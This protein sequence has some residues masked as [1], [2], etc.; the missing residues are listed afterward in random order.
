MWENTSEGSPISPVSRRRK[1]WRNGWMRPAP[2]RSEI[3]RPAMTLAGD[4]HERPASRDGAVMDLATGK[5]TSGVATRSRNAD[6][7]PYRPP[8][9]PLKALQSRRALYGR[10]LPGPFNVLRETDRR[11]PDQRPDLSQ[12][13]AQAQ[14]LPPVSSAAK[15]FTR[16]RSP[17][18]L[19]PPRCGRAHAHCL[20][21][22]AVAPE[23]E[24][25]SR[26]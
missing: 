16:S 21:P 1:R 9:T 12:T 6:P 4:D 19:L 14:L 26:P 24:D 8:L 3:R 18:A 13:Y 20:E 15:R 2:T 11:R 17:T 7:F 25:A 22:R 23:A 5:I 10:P